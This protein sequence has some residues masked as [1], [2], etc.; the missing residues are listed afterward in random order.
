MLATTDLDV[1]AARAAVREALTRRSWPL[2]EQDDVLVASV[3][4][5]ERARVRV[6][7]GLSGLVRI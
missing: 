7:R 4:G 6:Y 5:T 2:E 1:D 3:N